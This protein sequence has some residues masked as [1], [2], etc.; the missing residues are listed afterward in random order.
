[1]RLLA[2]K[3]VFGRVNDNL[4]RLIAREFTSPAD[5][6]LLRCFVEIALTKRKGIERVE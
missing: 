1:M 5:D 4:K 2:S 6:V 3:L